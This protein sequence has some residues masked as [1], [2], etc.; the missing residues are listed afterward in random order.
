MKCNSTLRNL[1]ALTIALTSTVVAAGQRTL[2]DN[3]GYTSYN[4]AAGDS[5]IIRSGVY[6]GYI[7]Q[8]DNGAKITVAAGASFQPSGVNNPRGALKNL[9]TVRFNNWFGT[10]GGFSVENYGNMTFAQGMQLNEGPQLWTNYYGATLRFE[11]GVAINAST[12]VNRGTLYSGGAVQLNSNATLTNNNRLEI[13]GDLAVN[14]STLNNAGKFKSQGIAFNSGAVLNNS[15]GL[16][17]DGPITN[18]SSL[19]N[20]GLLWSTTARGASNSRISNWGTLTNSSTGVVKSVDFVNSGTMAGTGDWYFTGVTENSGTVGI[21]GGGTDKMNIFDATRTSTSRIFDIQ[22]GNVNSSA[23]WTNL[24]AP[25]TT[26]TQ[27]TCAA[28]AR[29]TV[30]PVKWDFFTASL[31]DNTPVLTWASEQTSGTIFNIQRSY[32]AANFTTIGTINSIEGVKNYRFEDKQ[33]NTNNRSVYYRIRAVETT[34]EVSIS[35]TRSLSL[36]NKTAMS[37]QASP[38]PFTSQLNISYN[39]TVREKISIRIVSMNGAVMASKA[40]NVTTGYNNIA[41]TEAASLTKGM[42]LVQL[43]SENTVIASERVVKQ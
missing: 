10:N 18:S 30:L 21:N 23:K 37:V 35:E 17:I 28:E 41:I 36:A 15:C 3:G 20:N 5:L 11:S 32:D 26:R 42:Y 9:G 34:N 40:V 6:Q 1:F 25:D 29:T 13:A 12:V 31:T 43:I 33:V 19:Y 22:N 38:N 4:L 8:F 14:G 39:S 27:S 2:V 24:A 16:A 7:G